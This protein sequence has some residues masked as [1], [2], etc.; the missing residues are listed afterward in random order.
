MGRNLRFW[1]TAPQ[2]APFDPGDAPLALGALLLRASRTEHAPLF[3]LP[4]ML[5]I[6]LARRYDLTPAEASEMLEACARV[7]AAAP[8]SAEFAAVLHMVIDHADRYA[9]A[10]S[11]TDTLAS[12]GL[13]A[14]GDPRTLALC[15]A[16]LGVLPTEMDQPRRAS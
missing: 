1:L 16:F 12:V 2:A 10:L 4:G 3:A 11:L 13:C 14:P 5:S 6:V 7:E 8:A 15:E 9:M